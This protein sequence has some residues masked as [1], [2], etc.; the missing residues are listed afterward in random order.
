MMD[1]SIEPRVTGLLL[2]TAAGD[3]LGLPGSTSAGNGGSGGSPDRC[4]SVFCSGTA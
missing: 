4:A 1:Y 3:S 2:G